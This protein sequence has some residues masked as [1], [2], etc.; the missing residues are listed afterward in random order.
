MAKLNEFKTTGSLAEQVARMAK[1]LNANIREATKAGYMDFAEYKFIQKSL[2]NTLFA[3]RPSEKRKREAEATGKTLTVFAIEDKPANLQRRFTTEQLKQYK[4]VLENAQQ[5]IMYVKGKKGAEEFKKRAEVFKGRIE[6]TGANIDI[7]RVYDLV[8]LQSSGVWD[9][10]KN[11]GFASAQI[12]TCVQKVGAKLTADRFNECLKFY[13]ENGL[14]FNKNEC[15]QYIIGNRTL[16]SIV[17][18]YASFEG[19]LN[20]EWLEKYKNKQILN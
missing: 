3:S 7:T 12:V 2:T 9:K 13:E 18:R 17:A 6:A 11:K 14:P 16:N 10:M 5:K 19:A 8:K 1:N 4:E 15:L 20:N